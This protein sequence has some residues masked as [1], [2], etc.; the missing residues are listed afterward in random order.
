MAEEIIERI[1]EKAQSYHKDLGG[2]G[3]DHV[4]RVY[5]LGVRLTEKEDVDLMVLKLACLL[6]DIA[7]VKEDKGECEDHSEEGAIMAEEILKQ[8]NIPQE[9]INHISECI[10]VHRYSKG[11][12]PETKEAEILQDADRLEALGAIC[13]AR[14]FMYNGFNQNSMYDP[15]ISPDKE[16]HGQKNSTAVNH[17]YEKIL[18]IK[19]ESFHTELAKEVAK[20]RYD[21][22]VNFLEQFKAEWE[23]KK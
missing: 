21:Y 3:F 11:L 7:R 16:Y 10:R 18:K 15:K 17:F 9:K 6:H 5:N 8:E 1:R 12:K 4:E 20:E 14:V 23:G 2:H 13:I 22:I 19:P